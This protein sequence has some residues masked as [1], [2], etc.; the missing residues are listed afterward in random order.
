MKRLGKEVPTGIFILA[1]IAFLQGFHLLLNALLA[2]PN[3]LTAAIANLIFGVYFIICGSGLVKLKSEGWIL[4][5]IGLALYSLLALSSIAFG[6]SL[7]AGIIDIIIG[8]GLLIYLNR[9]GIKV[10]FKK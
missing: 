5:T 7:A 4:A 2:I 1:G 8:G 3:S 6:G 10:I 9:P